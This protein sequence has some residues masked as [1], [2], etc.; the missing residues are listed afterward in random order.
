MI[1]RWFKLKDQVVAMRKKGYSYRDLEL[2]FGIPRS[3]LNSWF[4]S[5]KLSKKHKEALYKRWERALGT[6]R[7]SA[8]VWHKTQ[9]L[10]RLKEAELQALEALKNIDMND[11][12][13]LNLALAML[14]L[15]EGFKKDSGATGMGNSDPMILKLFVSLLL[16]IY[17]VPLNKISCELHL[18][19]DQNPSI[20]K[21][22]WSQ[23]LGIPIDNFKSVSIDRRTIGSPT[24]SYYKGVCIVR[25]GLVAIQRKLMYTSR[26]FCQRVIDQ[27]ARSSI[28]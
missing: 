4:K 8:I 15:G 16:N 2:K 7:K 21:R 12:S 11:S 9:K 24:Y 3:T 14:Y 18:R 27:C 10:N 20:I 19:A 13:I 23:E 6:A 25:C 22:Y 1:S 17:L 5:L 28:G 26:I